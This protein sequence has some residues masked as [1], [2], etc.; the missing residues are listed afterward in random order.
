VL[1]GV[2]VMIWA[3]ELV[4]SLTLGPWLTF[5]VVALGAW[6]LVVV[7]CGLAPSVLGSRRMVAIGWVTLGAVLIG[8][9]L[10]SYFQIFNSPAY[11]TDEVA[12]DQYAALL[13]V[14]GH[15][16][17]V[18][19]MAP[20]AGLYHL[21]PSNFTFHLDGTPVTTLSYP[22]LSFLAYAPAMLLG[23]STQ[24]GIVLNVAAWAVAV[25]LLFLLL[26][27]SLR[28][29]ALVIGSFSVYI[30]YA[31]GGVTDAL[32]VPL[33]MGA[34]FQWDSFL[35]RRGL[36]RWIGPVL[37]G[38]AMAVKQTPWLVLPF[39]IAAVLIEGQRQLG[40]RGAGLR[41]G[42]QYLAAAVGAFLVPNLAFVVMSPGAWWRGILTP[43]GAHTV[44]VGQGLVG[45]SLF[46]GVGG[47]SLTA[48]SVLA[49][50]VLVAMWAVYVTSYPLLKGLTFFLPAFALFFSVRAS[51]SYLVA[52]VPAAIVGALTTRSAPQRPWSAWPWVVGVSIVLT[53]G[54]AAFALSSQSPLAMSIQQVYT[55]GQLA[56]IDRVVV[57]VANVSD[58][59]ARP[60]FSMET[61]TTLTAFWFFKGGPA[62]LKPG[63]AA[64]YTLESPDY[65]SQPSIAGGFQVVAFTDDP[66]TVSRTGSYLPTTYHVAL[67]PNAVDRIVPVGQPV[68]ITAEVLNH[69]DGPV[70]VSGIPVYLGQ[71]IYAQQGLEFGEAAINGDQPGVTPVSALTDA[72][73]RA[74]F[75]IRG[76]V[77]TGDPV[78]FEANLVNGT[79]YYPYGYSEIL[80]IRFVTNVG[81]SEARPH[82]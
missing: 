4:A 25:L 45:L 12:F 47:G 63:E 33:L 37:F 64:T 78:Y 28:P 38:L 79:Q 81:R 43:F 49:V 61:G 76:T 30:A 29:L 39:L 36:R 41:A 2:V 24:V 44:P 73:G 57:R 70:R 82:A 22:S 77:A 21:S 55:T 1:A 56:T 71:V 23:W 18:Q 7:A 75:V 65:P 34:A 48:F 5:A 26:P 60:A 46:V 11:P 14:H 10:W 58:R 8:L 19:S 51:G 74:K 27:R 42:G 13:L 17:Y 15:N 68:T 31:V 3:L 35:T 62:V 32:F 54:A 50:V 69:L 6:G 72:S 20:A 53:G 16:P 40:S 59:P 66:G 67:V 9:A 52:L 80:P